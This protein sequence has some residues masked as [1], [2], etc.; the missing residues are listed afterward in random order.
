MLR[1]HRYIFERNRYGP[2][3]LV[4]IYFK[5]NDEGLAFPHQLDY[6]EIALVAEGRGRIFFDGEPCALKGN[7]AYF[8]PPGPVRQWE[9]DPP[10]QAVVLIF[11]L[12]FIDQFFNDAL[13]LFKLQYFYPGKNPWFLQLNPDIFAELYR[14]L[15]AMDHERKS[16]KKD[17]V[18][19]LRAILYRLLIRLNRLYGQAYG[20]DDETEGLPLVKKL[21][22]LIETHFQKQ[23]KVETYA[24]MLHITP[25]HLN[26]LIKRHTG[27]TVGEHIRERVLAES[28][29]LLL[30]SEMNVAEI[31]WKLNFND[32]S[33]FVKYF[34]K[35]CNSTPLDFK[36]GVQKRFH[37]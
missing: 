28:K 10:F 24:G 30:F 2:E 20:V 29:R 36:R 3:L 12:D 21:R 15:E 26:W 19:M 33:Y 9:V 1:A 27:R 35:Y 8:T 13:F 4:D 7:S 23:R 5:R 14:E 16:L 37:P 22:Q 6:Y 32:P 31:A 17:S 11:T 34:K 18:H 25:G